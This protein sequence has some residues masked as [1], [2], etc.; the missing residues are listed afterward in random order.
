[1]QEPSPVLTPTEARQ[2]SP[3]R[4]NLRVLIVSM[5]A[6]VGIGALLFIGVYNPRSPIGLPKQPPAAE[7]TTA[8][9]PQ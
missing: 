5:V 1:M 4:M 3:R 9:A 7:D 6:L 8:P 2:A